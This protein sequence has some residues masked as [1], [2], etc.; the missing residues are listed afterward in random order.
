MNASDSNH[1]FVNF[2][3]FSAMGG[4]APDTGNKFANLAKIHG[5][6]DVP[7]SMCVT[8]DFF[9]DALEERPSLCAFLKDYFSELQTTFGCFLVDSY[10]TLERQVET[11]FSLR[12]QMI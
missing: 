3:T 5:V 4:D 8:V 7:D 1:Y 6:V 2:Q 10:K 11:K 12:E 9:R